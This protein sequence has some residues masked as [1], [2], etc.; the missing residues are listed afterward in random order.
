METVP[1]KKSRLAS[2]IFWCTL[3]ILSSLVV[4]AV[5]SNLEHNQPFLLIFFVGASGTFLLS[6]VYILLGS[7]GL[8]AENIATLKLRRQG[9]SQAEN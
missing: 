6:I 2:P 4:G 5:F 7:I 9:C 1:E 8:L 3:L